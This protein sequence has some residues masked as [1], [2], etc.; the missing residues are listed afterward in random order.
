MAAPSDDVGP[1]EPVTKRARVDATWHDDPHSSPARRLTGL[2]GAGI[3]HSLSPAMHGFAYRRLG[4]DGFYQLMDLDTLPGGVDG[5]LKPALLALSACGFAGAN[6]TMPVKQRV[7]PLLDEV[8]PAAEAI[9]AVNTVVCGPG[10]RLVGHNTDATGFSRAMAERFPDAAEL[11]SRLRCVA[12][13]GAGGASRAVC[14]AMLVA[15]ARVVVLTDPEPGQ[16]ASLVSDLRKLDFDAEVTAAESA[17]EALATPGLTGAVNAS[18][19]GMAGFRAAS[20]GLDAGFPAPGLWLGDTVY[21]PAAT[22]WILAGEARGCPVVRGDR[23]FLHQMVA[24]FELMN[25]PLEVGAHSDALAAELDRLLAARSPGPAY[26]F[27]PAAAST[28]PGE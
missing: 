17:A 12:V 23:M 5:G 16:A 27:T 18:P 28:A 1:T 2:I 4:V 8:S 24:G 14:Y 22:P 19:V 26:K 11:Q 25:A 9:G 20:H 3:S 21:V 13:I 15:G 6:V 7:L 10:G